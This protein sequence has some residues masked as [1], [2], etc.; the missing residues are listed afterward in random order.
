MVVES[1]EKTDEAGEACERRLVGGEG[2]GWEK[3]S[4]VEGEAGGKRSVGAVAVKAT[5]TTAEGEAEGRRRWAEVGGAARHLPLCPRWPRRNTA[6]PFSR[7]VSGN[8]G[9]ERRCPDA[10]GLPGVCPPICQ[11]LACVR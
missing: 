4:A 2:E 7:G 5:K 1:C 6:S 8:R 3:S 9:T 10:G 11:R